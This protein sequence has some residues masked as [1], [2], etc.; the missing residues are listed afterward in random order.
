MLA[1]L[2]QPIFTAPVW[3][4][5]LLL[6]SPVTGEETKFQ[7]GKALDLWSP[8]GMQQSWVGLTALGLCLLALSLTVWQEQRMKG[9]PHILKKGLPRLKG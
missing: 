2:S 5:V 4:E 1:Y 8:A 7:R 3:G 9:K 6:L